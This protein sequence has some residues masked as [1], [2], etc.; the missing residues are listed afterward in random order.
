MILLGIHSTESPFFPLFGRDP[1]TPFKKLL[2]PKI[3]YLGDERGLLDLEAVRYA[4][5][6]AR[7]NI[8]LNTQRSDK[9]HTPTRSPNQFKVGDLVYIKTMPPPFG[10]P[11]GFHLIK[12]S[13]PHNAILQNTLNGKTRIVN[14]GDMQLSGPMNVIAAEGYSP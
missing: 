3:R 7:K 2:S 1:L 6:L 10:N 11:N 9:D 14:I 12:F 8:C 4:L 13:T 5:A